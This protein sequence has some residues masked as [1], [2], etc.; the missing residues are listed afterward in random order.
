[1][2]HRVCGALAH[3]LHEQA[4]HPRIA[5]QPALHAHLHARKR[6]GVHHTRQPGG[7]IGLTRAAQLLGRPLDKGRHLPERLLVGA[8]LQVAVQDG[9][10]L[11]HHVVHAGAHGG[12]GLVARHLVDVSQAGSQL[13]ARLLQRARC[14]R[15]L[16]HH[17][18]TLRHV[19]GRDPAAGM[20]THP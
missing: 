1:M 19:H 9:E 20:S 11:A 12:E 16:C 17:P 5:R 14:L 13:D 15:E 6:E 18:L 2:A 3:H 4:G 10:A 8:V 7:R